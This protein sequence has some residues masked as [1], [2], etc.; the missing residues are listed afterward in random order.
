[1]KMNDAGDFSKTN[2]IKP[3]RKTGNRRNFLKTVAPVAS[4]TV[5]ASIRALAEIKDL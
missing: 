3:N 1:M 5:V 4:G 2:P